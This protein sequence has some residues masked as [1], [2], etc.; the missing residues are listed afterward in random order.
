MRVCVADLQKKYLRFLFR[1]RLHSMPSKTSSVVWQLNLATLHIFRVANCIVVITCKC[2]SNV[3]K[4]RTPHLVRCDPLV[5]QFE[6]TTRCQIHVVPGQVTL[7]M[8]CNTLS[9]RLLFLAI[10]CKHNINIIHKT[11]STQHTATLSEGDRAT[12]MGNMNK[13][14]IKLLDCS[15]GWLGNRV[16]SVLD[17][18]AV[19]PGFRSHP[20]RLCSPSSEI[21]SNPLKGCEGNCRP[22]GK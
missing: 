7:S 21:G 14:L 12:A 16:V 6:H 2:S 15:F 19:G 20:S 13:Q 17:S 4:F 5:G 11:R 8:F 1:W 3:C 22:G 10:M 18:G 9:L